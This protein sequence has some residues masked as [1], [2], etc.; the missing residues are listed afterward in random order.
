V[1]TLR[2]LQRRFGALGITAAEP[3]LPNTY[4]LDLPK[5]ADVLAAARQMAGDTAVA[6]AEPNYIRY[7][8]RTVNDPLSSFQYA[9]NK[10]NAYGAW[11][12]TTGS[13]VTIA[14][15][16][17]GVNPKHLDFGGRVLPGYDF[18]NNDADASDDVFHGTQVAGII[19]A[20]GDNG[21]GVSGLCWGCRLLPVKVLGSGGQGSDEWVAKG[22]RWAV[23]HGARV[24]NMS[25]G[26][27]N[28]SSLLHD[29]VKYATSKNVLVVAAAG[30][31]ADKGNPID[32]PAAYDEALAVGAT[33]ENDEHAYFSQVHPYVDVSAPGWNIASTGAERNLGGYAAATGT[34]FA[35]PYVA[36]LAGLLLSLNPSLDVN[37]L[38]ALIVNNVDDLGERGHDWAFGAGRINAARAVAA[39]RVPAFERVSNPNQ[40]DVIFFEQTG[41]TLRGALRGFWEQN[42]GLPVFG[43]P[44]SEEFQETTPD[45]VFTV[46]YFERN[47]LEA[48]PEKPAPYNVLLGRLSDTL[49]Q[50]QGRNWFTFP[51]GK[52]APNCEFFAETGHS[53]CEPFLGF[54][55]ANGLRDPNLPVAGRALALFGMPLSEPAMEQNSSGQTV[56]TQW[57][58]RARF[59]LHPDKPAPHQV[60]L[61]LLGNESARSRSGGTAAS[62]K[63]PPNRCEGVA[64]PV[65]VTVRPSG[66]ILI[67]TLLTVDASG[68]RDNEKVDYFYSAPGGEAVPVSTVQADGD[69]HIRGRI[70]VLGL[71]PGFWA[72]V[73]KGKKSRHEAVIYLKV[74]DR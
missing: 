39:V 1:D 65:N 73:F 59:E 66:C 14:V 23:D 2:S 5:S 40:P 57:F 7:A 54:W 24:I 25:L 60:L 74:V 52:P 17:S 47:R 31:E 63:Q 41:H 53:L 35:A 37:G 6:Y 36:G 20:S 13:G 49:L 9:L 38:K 22:I 27:P 18:A 3:V 51:K 42:G 67:G 61:G 58:E 33:D 21:E 8:L 19:A 56:L 12:V 48:H 44:I 70:G 10:I 30:N 72:V 32:Y 71:D 11:D 50:R 45:G 68:F 15:I 55:K 26:G 64:P 62:G 69:G 16:D 4:R 43:Y 34:S 29:A 28:K 46:Q